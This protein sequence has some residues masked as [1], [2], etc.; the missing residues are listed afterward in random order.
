MISQFLK[1]IYPKAKYIIVYPY[2]NNDRYNKLL[3]ITPKNLSNHNILFISNGPDWYYKGLDILIDSF[4][5]LKNK[6]QDAKLF[7]LGEW[8]DKIKKS[9]K[10][11]VYCF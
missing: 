8:D 3:N 2:I 5:E 11:T 4:L 6:I 10:M 7:I 9:S 1:E